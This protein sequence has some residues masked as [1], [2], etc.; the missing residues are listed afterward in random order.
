MF[1]IVGSGLTSHSIPENM[2]RRSLGM[3]GGISYH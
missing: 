1:K 2:D 3:W